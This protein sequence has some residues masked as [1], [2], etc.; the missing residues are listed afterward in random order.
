MKAEYFASN[1][2]Q[3]KNRKAQKTSNRIKLIEKQTFD[4]VRLV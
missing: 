1:A 3:M 2:K 4:D